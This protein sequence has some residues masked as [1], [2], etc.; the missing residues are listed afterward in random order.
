MKLRILTF[1]LIFD[2]VARSV[3]MKAIDRLVEH[4]RPAV[5]GFQEVMRDAL[6]ML[7]DQQW[8]TATRP[9]RMRFDID[10]SWSG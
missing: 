8:A 10:W 1:N 2:E 5:I 3:R 7:K 9:Y 4:F 6:A